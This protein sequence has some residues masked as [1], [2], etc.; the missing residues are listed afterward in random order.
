MTDIA[1]AKDDIAKIFYDAWIADSISQD[2][3]VYFDKKDDDVSLKNG[4]S[5]WARF[6]IKH[7]DGGFSRQSLT[8]SGRK[9]SY[10]RDGV[11]IIGIF[12]PIGEGVTLDSSLASIAMGAFEGKT[13]PNGVWFR[14]ARFN[15]VGVSNAWFQTNVKVNFNYSEIK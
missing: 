9:K 3:K 2:I 8:D 6:T 10:Q 14:S 11:V 13:T 5:S 1:T 4:S 15:E 12:T 7:F